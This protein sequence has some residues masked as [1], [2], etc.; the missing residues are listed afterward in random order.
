MAY[1]FEMLK[2][3]DAGEELS[4]E[5]LLGLAYEYSVEDIEG[6]NRRWS[7]S[8][9]SYVQLGDRHFCIEWEQGLTEMQ[10]DECYEQPYEVIKNTY[11]KVIPEHKE[12][13]TEWIKKNK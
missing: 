13:V 10:P 8:I 9:T 7:R 4:E 12:T 1:E 6:D 11:E 2:K 5:E 3:I